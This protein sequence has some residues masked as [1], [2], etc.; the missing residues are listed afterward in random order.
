M[1]LFS[2]TL[3]WVKKPWRL[4]AGAIFLSISMLA[5]RGESLMVMRRLC[6][7]VLIPCLCI[8]LIGKKSQWFQSGYELDEGN[9]IVNVDR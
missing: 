9:D 8:E 4:A 6:T 7:L 5:A 1:G 2:G 3:P